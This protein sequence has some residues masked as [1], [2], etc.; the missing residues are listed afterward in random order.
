MA[1]SIFL[2]DG[3][4]CRRIISLCTTRHAI[5]GANKKQGTSYISCNSCVRFL[6]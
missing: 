6:L 3:P 4:I 1:N 5:S 2:A